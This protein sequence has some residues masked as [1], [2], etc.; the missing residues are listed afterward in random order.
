MITY[1]FPVFYTMYLVWNG[2]VPEIILYYIRIQKSFV[3]Y[4][5][6]ILAGRGVRTF[7]ADI[8]I[9]KSFYLLNFSVWWRKGEKLHQRM[10]N[11]LIFLC[12]LTCASKSVN[13]SVPRVQQECRFVIAPAYIYLWFNYQFELH[14]RPHFSITT[15]SE[16]LYN[17][18]IW[19]AKNIGY[20]KRLRISGRKSS[21]IILTGGYTYI[22]HSSHT[23][24]IEK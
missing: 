11:R 8:V 15:K 7:G 21:I 16:R 2:H 22:A 17:A 18:W 20:G 13:S 4:R 9:R 10:K 3:V 12:T 23:H 5:H 1:S 14:Y 19:Q 24:K 6:N